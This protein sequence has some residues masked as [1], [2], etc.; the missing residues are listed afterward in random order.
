MAIFLMAGNTIRCLLILMITGIVH[1]LPASDDRLSLNATTT[2]FLISDCDSRTSIVQQALALAVSSLPDAIADAQ[3]GTAS[4]HGFTAFFK[5]RT[6]AP[7]V[8][9]VLQKIHSQ[10]PVRGRWPNL[11]RA[12]PPEFICAKFDTVLRYKH[13]NFD[14]YLACKRPKVYGFWAK[15][16]RYIVLCDYFFERP[17]APTAPRSETCIKVKDNSFQG[18]GNLLCLYQKYMLIHEMVHFYLGTK[19]LGWSTQPVEKYALNDAV[20]LNAE[21]SLRNPQNYQAFVASKWYQWTL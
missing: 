15:R 5:Q 9:T 13:L 14:P 12:S 4:T 19:G 20:D 6:S 11:I 2:R 21:L 3:L 8:A 7:A 17:P 16:S 18:F 10:S 1:G